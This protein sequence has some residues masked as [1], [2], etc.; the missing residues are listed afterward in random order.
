[1]NIERRI[2]FFLGEEGIPAWMLNRLKT[3][4]H[5]FKAV[6]VMRNI[7]RLN[8]AN[9]EQPMQMMS[10]GSRPGD[11]CQLLIEGT[12]AELACMTLT[13]FIAEHCRL[14]NSS[15]RQQP[16]RPTPTTPLPFPFSLHHLAPCTDKNAQLQAISRLVI[17]AEK[18]QQDA[19][20]HPDDIATA[21]RQLFEQLTARESVSSTA[22]G[23]GIALPHVLSPLVSQPHI[24]VTA[25][26]TPLDWGSQRGPVH[27]IVGLVLPAPPQRPHLE[28]FSSFSQQ[29]LVTK[30]CQA[31][32]D[33]TH[34]DVL[35]A[36]I[37]HALAAPFDRRAP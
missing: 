18:E 8:I 13:N 10:L 22:M 30:Y 5:Y 15:Y 33:N 31:L 1:M 36:I 7:S 14:I 6:V 3:L 9:A 21:T 11:L 37:V 2:T 29:L 35:E 27:R 28:A 25:L 20:P 34:P 19:P 12:D 17:I 23:N 32:G 16:H 24:S 26:D 4:A